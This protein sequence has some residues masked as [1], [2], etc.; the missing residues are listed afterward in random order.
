MAGIQLKMKM[1]NKV[2][3]PCMLITAPG[4]GG[5][6]ALIEEMKARNANNEDKMIFV[7]MHQSPR[8][9]TKSRYG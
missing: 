2:S 5:K 4:G 6:T 7:S 9:C 3:A 1:R 8:F